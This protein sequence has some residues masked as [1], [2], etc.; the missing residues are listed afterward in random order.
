MVSAMSWTMCRRAENKGRAGFP[1]LA[2]VPVDKLEIVSPD[3]LHTYRTSY[4]GIE[5]GEVAIEKEFFF[6][7]GVGHT[8]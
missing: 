7:G 4:E 6:G 1:S 3:M 8:H 2:E 5:E